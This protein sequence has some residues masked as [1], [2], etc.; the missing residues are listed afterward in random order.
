MNPCDSE[1]GSSRLTFQGYALQGAQPPVLSR[2]GHELFLLKCHCILCICDT[3]VQVG[4]G[5]AVQLKPRLH[6]TK[7]TP[8][9][10]KKRHSTFYM[11][12]VC[13]SIKAMVPPP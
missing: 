4:A 11:H 13:I 1:Q 2:Q 10:L 3:C 7:Q 5:Q 9:Q 6:A 12:A 8:T